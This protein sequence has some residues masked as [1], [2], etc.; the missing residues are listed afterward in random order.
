LQENFDRFDNA[1]YK[2]KEMA[3]FRRCIIVL[4]AL[5][6]LLGTATMASA[7]TPTAF[8]CNA[9]AT[10]FQVRHEGETEKLGDFLV[11]CTGGT[12]VAPAI[13]APTVNIQIFL[14]VNDTNRIMSASLHA[15]DALLLVDEPSQAQQVVCPAPCTTPLLGTGAGADPYVTGPNVFQGQIPTGSGADG[16]AN[17]SII[18]T[19]IPIAPPG[20]TGRQLVFRIT[21]IRG[22]A[23]ELPVSAIPSQVLENVSVSNPSVLPIQSFTAQ[24]TVAVVLPGILVSAST[25]DA[26]QQCFS[27]TDAPDGSITITEGFPSSFKVL[28]Q[29]PSQDTPGATYTPDTES[30]FWGPVISAAIGANAGLADHATRFRVFFTAVNSG[31][32]VN[33]PAAVSLLNVNTAAIT[34]SI[35]AVATCTG[36]DPTDNCGASGSAAS[37]LT[38]PVTVALDS[39]GNGEVVYEVV[40]TNSASTEAATIPFTITYV[41]SPGTGSPST[42]PPQAM[43]GASFAPLGAQPARW[44]DTTPSIPRFTDSASS[45][46]F[47]TIHLCAS[48]LLFPYVTNVVGFDT[49]L[50]IANTSQDPYGTSTQAGT[51]TLNWYG[52]GGPW[53][54]TTTPSVPAGTTWAS[55]AMAL[56]PAFNGYVIADCQ[57]QFAHGFAFVTRVGAVD[58]AMGYLALVIPDNPGLGTTGRVPNP[59]SCP[60]GGLGCG[61]G[62]GEQLGE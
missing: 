51:C 40:G 44:S 57:F 45:T 26:F 8:A 47:I 53:A 17:N 21:N 56:Q 14:N 13:A 42:T 7:Q 30:F 19:G 22:D 23:T 60:V 36:A 28:S 52:A 9:T 59:V 54:P 39:G 55:T 20:T 6:L 32:T 27:E 58:V 4:A 34:G 25:N 3:D 15:T 37:P 31:V 48:H 12:S 50:A 41:A 43:V 10:P 2:E 38:D 61:A 16:F 5:A 49:G 33:V 29:L 1:L 62:T 35:V 11:V 18:F 46:P 24:Q